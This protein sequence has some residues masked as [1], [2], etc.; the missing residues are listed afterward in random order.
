MGLA[1]LRRQPCWEA[2]VY[3][4]VFEEQGSVFV[5]H[6]VGPFEELSGD[7]FKFTVH[8]KKKCR[9]KTVRENHP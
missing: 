7:F 3:H 2:H 5:Q 6:S 9:E 4:G 1:E 8:F